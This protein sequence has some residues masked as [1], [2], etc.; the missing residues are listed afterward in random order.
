MN[1]PPQRGLF[2]LFITLIILSIQCPAQILKSDYLRSIKI[3]A[4]RGWR[5]YPQSVEDWKKKPNNHELWGYDAP[6]GHVYLADLLGYLYLNPRKNTPY[7]ARAWMEM[8][9]AS[10][11]FRLRLTR[12]IVGTVL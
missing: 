3:A 7:K 11:A 10:W 1:L 6:A 12:A 4:D 8:N 2:S 9:F 5:D